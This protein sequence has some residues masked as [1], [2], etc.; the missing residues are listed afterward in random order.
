MSEVVPLPLRARAFV[1]GRQ[2][3]RSGHSRALI[4]RPVCSTFAPQLSRRIHDVGRPPGSGRHGQ[5]RRD[6]RQSAAGVSADQAPN[7]Q[8]ELGARSHEE[9]QV[10]R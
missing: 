1:N 2:R 6:Y 7:G 3:S 9:I 8:L 5:Q 10:A 4:V